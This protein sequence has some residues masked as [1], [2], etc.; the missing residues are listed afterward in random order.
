M[1]MTTVLICNSNM[2][3]PYVLSE[4]LAHEDEQYLI[5]SDIDNMTRFFYEIKLPNAAILKYNHPTSF[6]KIF[7]SRRFLLRTTDK[8]NVERIVFFHT[9]FGGIINWYISKKAKDTEICYC[10]VFN[11][12]PYPKARGIKA[13]YYWLSDYILHGVSMEILSRPPKL[14]PSLPQSFFKKV[15]AKAINIEIDYC[16]IKKVLADKFS[17]IVI[18]AKV[19]F[20]TGS[21]VST[22]FVEEEEYTKKTNALIDAIGADMCVAKCHPRFK[23]VFG[24]ELELKSIPSYIPGNLIIG[25]Y[26]VFISNHSTMLVEAAIAGKTAISLIDYYH[27]TSEDKIDQ[28]KSF[29]NERLEGRG[30]IFYPKSLE[31]VLGIIKCE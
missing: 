3:V 6:R 29:Y 20:L 1:G 8:Y 25:S 16:K 31:E 23:D 15:G 27:Q 5:M 21:T 14:L 30:K 11:S 22:G 24:K 26:E 28:I 19:V 12:L 18:D 4:V 17:E 2:F 13:M 7:K 9:E 10:K